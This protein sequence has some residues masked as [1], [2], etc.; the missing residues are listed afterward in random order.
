MSATL[1]GPLFNHRD[2]HNNL[3]NFR[4]TN[5]GLADRAGT[6]RLQ[7][8]HYS[9]YASTHNSTPDLRRAAAG[10]PR[11]L[12]QSTPAQNSTQPLS[13]MEHPAKRDRKIDW[14]DFY[15]NGPPK[16]VIVI[17]DDESPPPQSR[18]SDSTMNLRH[19]PAAGP[20]AN[21]SVRHADKKRK[22][23]ASAVYDPVYNKHYSATQT[24]HHDES[25]STS[26]STDRTTSAY[27]TAATSLASQASNGAWPIAADQE[28]VGQKRKRQTTRKTAADNKKR[29][30][31]LLKDPYNTYIR[32]APPN[33]PVKAQDVRVPIVSPV[34][35]PDH[36]DVRH[37][38]ISSQR[39]YHPE[40]CD[41][42]DG[43]YIVAPDTEL[44]DRCMLPTD[45]VT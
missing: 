1:A 3:S 43:H 12:Q 13:D 31:E 24:P 33:P 11:S 35:L 36:V 20:S 4:N 44:T 19:Q 15:K 5:T 38:L 41:D 10:T 26:I 45:A 14:N 16:E 2:Y 27:N 30:V 7:N 39:S 23:A 28:V 34:G 29:E 37:S 32:G 21:R 8:S 9:G 18:Q 6:P 17:D 42:E 40:K 22:T 25:G